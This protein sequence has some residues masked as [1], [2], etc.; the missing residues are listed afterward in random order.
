MLDIIDSHFHMWDLN[1]LELPWL[2]SVSPQLNRSFEASEL[3]ALYDSYPD[4]N[5]VG[6]IHIEADVTQPHEEELLVN[7]ASEEEPRLLGHVSHSRLSREISVPPGACGI[8]EVLHNDDIPPSRVLE[9]SFLA[10]LEQLGIAG[11][12]FDAVVR[13]AE[14]ENLAKACT[15]V[16]DAI[17]VIDHLGNIKD[18]TDDYRRNMEA[19]ADLPN[20][21]C[22]ISG[23]THS[24]TEPT[25]DILH[26][27]EN[28]F[29]RDRLMYA[30]NWPVI[31][32]YSNFSRHLEVTR[33]YF[34][35]DQDIFSR[36]A[37]NVYKLKGDNL[38]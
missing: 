10:G 5:F 13:P 29:G 4:I 38:S 1:K 35:D 18:F 27:I 12:P 24:E 8:R 3:F 11:I 34:G 17:I 32:T 16:T 20:V 15:S 14:L 33:E 9:D 28:A 23:L 36:T 2:S 21:Y 22:K 19:L 31:G 7:K 25:E 6:A 26:F 30:S 37:H